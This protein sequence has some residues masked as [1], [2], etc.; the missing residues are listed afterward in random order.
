[1]RHNTK[2]LPCKYLQIGLLCLLPLCIVT[3][4][5]TQETTAPEMMTAEQLDR[6]FPIPEAKQTSSD[7]Y[8]LLVFAGKSVISGGEGTPAT[9]D[10]LTPEED[11]RRQRAFVQ[12]NA[13]ALAM[14]DEALKTPIIAP[15]GRNFDDNSTF[16]RGAELSKLALLM[17]QRNRV[18]AADKQWD[19]ALNGTV[20]IIRIGVGSISNGGTVD[21]SIGNDLQDLGR[22]DA[23]KWIAHS[24]APTALQAAQSLQL[25][26][27]SLRSADNAIQEEKWRELAVLKGIVSSPEW[28][29][30]QR[31]GK[32]L[33]ATLAQALKNPAE[34]Q[35]LRKISA[36]DVLR[37]YLETMDAVAAQAA[38]PFNLDTAPI[39]PAGDPF[40]DFWTSLYTM[41]R[42][43][44]KDRK[45]GL[46]VLRRVRWEKTRTGNRLLMTA[47][48]LQA[49]VKDNAHYPEK[50]E[51]LRGKYLPEIP[52]DPF[53][54]NAP[55][56][57]QRQGETYALYSVG[58]NG[59]DNG[60][61]PIENKDGKMVAKLSAEGDIVAGDFK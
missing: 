48:A 9:E 16:D 15:P 12:K 25:L 55:L 59:V 27:N 42:P 18:Y 14:M 50:L 44:T 40:S 17:M 46:L 19:K 13:Q 8:D 61:T 21:M 31:N 47:I 35:A 36:A 5:V 7:S 43:D 3:S 39:E 60:G 29:E 2:F 45:Y 11:L 26:D 28:I 10:K 41:S 1:M 33:G 38:L 52:V 49:F 4:G 34:V 37:H 57:Y 56:R 53:G 51:E 24:D 6:E 20:E 30:F 23:W 58:P 54:H 22:E 32:G